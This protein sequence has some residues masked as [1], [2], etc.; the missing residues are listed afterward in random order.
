MEAPLVVLDFR[1]IAAE[2]LALIGIS[3]MII[4]SV[5]E[6]VGLRDIVRWRERVANRQITRALQK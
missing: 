2:E 1:V 4:S 3:G 5:E 6:G